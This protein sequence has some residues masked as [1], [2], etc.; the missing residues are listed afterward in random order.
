MTIARPTAEGLA[1]KR[2]ALSANAP[3]TKLS[4]P[5]EEGALLSLLPL[6]AGL[7]RGLRRRRA[8]VGDGGPL[9]APA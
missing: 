7:G 3:F 4:L 2:H 1:A 9:G 5:A 8:G 6:N